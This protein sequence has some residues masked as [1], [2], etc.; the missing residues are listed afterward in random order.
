ME[1]TQ[2]R[3]GGTGAVGCG[4]EGRQRGSRVG[5]GL[6]IRPR[7]NQWAERREAGAEEPG[8][9]LVG[10]LKAVPE[11]EAA[12]VPPL[13]QYSQHW[14]SSHLSPVYR[15]WQRHLGCLRALRKQLPPLKHCRLQVPGRGA[16]G[17]TI[18]AQS[19]G[20][21]GT[22][23]R[24]SRGRGWG[25]GRGTS[26]P[27]GGG[28]GEGTA[29]QVPL[30]SRFPL[31]QV[32]TGPL[33]LSRQSHSHFLRSQGLVTAGVGRGGRM[34]SLVDPECPRHNAQDPR[35]QPGDSAPRPSRA[36]TGLSPCAYL[37]AVCVGG[38]G[39]HR[40]RGSGPLSG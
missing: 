35:L 4:Q 21:R 16:A 34:L 7:R 39:P 17:R 38:T 9:V 23:G 27:S 19:Q 5:Q 32:Q 26:I 10:E 11:G 20:R 25:P 14:S 22:Q 1:G 31:G 6:G 30:S 24:R 3:N 15:G 8:A 13:R 28:V 12:Q 18:R 36:Q 37:Q 40:R 33:G 2:Q 29:T